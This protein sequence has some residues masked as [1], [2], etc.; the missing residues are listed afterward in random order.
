MSCHARR[1]SFCLSPDPL[2]RRNKIE[3]TNE[4]FPS[5][6]VYSMAQYTSPILPESIIC[7]FLFLIKTDLLTVQSLPPL[8]CYLQSCKIKI[9]NTKLDIIDL[10]LRFSCRHQGTVKFAVLLAEPTSSF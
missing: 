8:R 4:F 3:I 7:F 2:G 6:Q 9:V 1:T 10:A 5:I